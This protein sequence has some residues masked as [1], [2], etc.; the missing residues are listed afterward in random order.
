MSEVKL[1]NKFYCTE[2]NG[3]ISIGSKPTHAGLELWKSAASRL[4]MQSYVDPYC[5]SS[6]RSAQYI[7][8]HC[9][10]WSESTLGDPSIDIFPLGDIPYTHKPDHIYIDNNVVVLRYYGFTGTI[11][12][13]QYHALLSLPNTQL[14]RF[15]RNRGP[16]NVNA[17]DI[18][19]ALVGLNFM[20]PLD[21]V[22]VTLCDD[23]KLNFNG[24]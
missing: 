7:E 20:N 8:Y 4:P 19:N 11:A 24:A 16:I 3:V 2:Y 23:K 6:A 18:L 13:I 9:N 10:K 14:V 22:Y 5:T 12:D 21:H 1:S 15:M 17:R